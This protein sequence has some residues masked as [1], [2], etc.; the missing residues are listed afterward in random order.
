MSAADNVATT[1]SVPLGVLA[2]AFETVQGFSSSVLRVE[3][4]RNLVRLGDWAAPHY[5]RWSDAKLA[6]AQRHGKLSDEGRGLY[7]FETAEAAG[8]FDAEMKPLAEEAIEL[9]GPAAKK[10]S[11]RDFEGIRI[12]PAALL[13]LDAFVELDDG[14]ELAA[15]EPETTLAHAAV[16]A[17]TYG[18]FA[19]QELDIKL[20]ARIVRL[21]RWAAPHHARVVEAR[22]AAAK[23]YGTADGDRWVLSREALGSFNAELAPLLAEKVQTAVAVDLSDDKLQLTPDQLRVLTPFLVA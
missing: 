13:T 14:V 20:A 8:A 21:M 7:R 6:A 9:T 12:R 18:Q 15:A 17:E 2:Q 19:G 4:A 22:A 1:N 11:L 5:Q 23:K 16:L 3:V 10:L